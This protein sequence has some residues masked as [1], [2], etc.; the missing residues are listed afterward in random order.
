MRSVDIRKKFS[1]L[2]SA[3]NEMI[4]RLD[5][6]YLSAGTD[7]GEPIGFRGNCQRMANTEYKNR[8]GVDYEYGSVYVTPSMTRIAI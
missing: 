3:M 4:D 6:E 5:R 1:N 8:F 7:W 2:S